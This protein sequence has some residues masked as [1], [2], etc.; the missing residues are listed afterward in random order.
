FWPSRQTSARPLIPP[1]ASNKKSR[2]ET[3]RPLLMRRLHS[4]VI[5]LIDV[6]EFVRVQH[7]VR[8]IGQGRQ[9]GGAGCARQ[10]ILALLPPES[11]LA[12][13]LFRGRLAA[14]GDAI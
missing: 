10:V 9:I 11:Q 13:Q 12:F 4:V 8:D 2:R 7:H 1:P 14:E 6:D 3:N 5:C